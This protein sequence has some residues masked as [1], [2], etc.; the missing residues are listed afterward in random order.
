MKYRLVIFFAFWLGQVRGGTI[1]VSPTSPVNTIARALQLARKGDTLR[2]KPGVYL[3]SNLHVTQPL[4]IMGESF[5]IIDGQKRNEILVIESSDVKVEGLVIR[6]GGYSSYN[7]IAALRI[8]NAAR[9]VIRNN[10]IENTFFGIYTQHG[11]DCLIEGNKLQSNAA[12]EQN[13]ANGIHCWKSDRMRITNNTVSGHRDGI[14]FEFV[15][16][17]T[18]TGNL[19]YGN[20]RYGLHFMFSNDDSYV[21][22][23]FRN[24]GAGVAVMYSHHVIMQNNQFLDNWGDAAYGL[25]LK[26]I[27]DGELSGNL[28]QR[29]SIALYLEGTNR[30]DVNRNRFL[31]NGWA[32][33]I[34][35]N[36]DGNRIHANNFSGNSFDVATNGTLV[37]NRFEDNYW[38]K[39]EGYDLDRDGKGDV[40]YRPMSVYSLIVERNPTSLMLF[41]SFM[42]GLLDRSEKIV[43]GLTPE[44]LKDDS[45]RMKPISLK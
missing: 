12:D 25:L 30:M 28:F 35:A 36:C 31:S 38:D 21:N 34:Q 20:V 23:Q 11:T 1:V 13:S 15:T 5:P 17:S 45:P 42:V 24:N 14:Y 41:R 4:V 16:H 18:V 8:V 3:E 7:D 26:E 6:N 37:L 32:L 39:Y 44:A 2:I 22:N 29:N 19:S 10:K 27:A 33:K 9:V 40:P 43:P